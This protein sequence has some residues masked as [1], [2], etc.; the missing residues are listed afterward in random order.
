[1]SDVDE[2]NWPDGVEPPN[3]I[4]I[5]C[6]SS[7]SGNSSDY[8][9][10]AGYGSEDGLIVPDDAIEDESSQASLDEVQERE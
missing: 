3:A 8:H 6:E 4:D 7:R 5:E 1:M 10:D 9:N 2:M